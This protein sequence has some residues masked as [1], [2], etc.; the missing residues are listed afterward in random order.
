MGFPSNYIKISSKANLYRQIGNS[1]AV[2]M[3]EAVM[4]QI[5]KQGFI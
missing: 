5:K 1:V 3:I 2:P 4:K